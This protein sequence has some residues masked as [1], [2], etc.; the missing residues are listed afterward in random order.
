MR[1]KSAKL[2]L[3]EPHHVHQD[4]TDL[5]NLLQIHMQMGPSSNLCP[6]APISSRSKGVKPTPRPHSQGHR[7]KIL[8]VAACEW[9]H[10]FAVRGWRIHSCG[11]DVT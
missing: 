6:V 9:L 3:H 4:P 5:S 1:L 7:C 10:V 8:P 11:P 2:H